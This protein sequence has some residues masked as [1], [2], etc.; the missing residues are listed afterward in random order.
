MTHSAK[1]EAASRQQV[2]TD[3]TV[4]DTPAQSPLDA[5]SLLHAAGISV[6]LAPDGQLKLY[7]KSMVAPPHFAAVRAVKPALLEL[8]R[9]DPTLGYAHVHT[10]TD[11]A[12][13]DL[14]RVAERYELAPDAELLTT[15]SHFATA[16]NSAYRHRDV[17]LMAS[18][19][20]DF[21]AVLAPS[22]PA[23]AETRQTAPARV[24][25]PAKPVTVEIP[26]PP[27]E[28]IP[29]WGTTT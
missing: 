15:S 11:L 1:A 12:A 29:L 8:L 26:E 3:V 9:A 16:F 2:A 17:D 6:R 19:E 14:S 23:K 22:P 27:A 18:L 7:P 5:L 25:E 24:L 10:L 20:R 21:A 4:A 13:A 28:Q